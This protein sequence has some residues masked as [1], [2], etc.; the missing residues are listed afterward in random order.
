MATDVSTAVTA[1]DKNELLSLA[2]IDIKY[3]LR[4]LDGT[5]QNKTRDSKILGI[6]RTTLREKIS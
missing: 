4:V 2:E 5:G 1:D 3:I 6:S